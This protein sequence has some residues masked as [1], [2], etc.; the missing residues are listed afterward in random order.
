[1]KTV[2]IF[3]VYAWL[4]ETFYRFGEITLAEINERWVKT[5]MSGGVPML[6]QTFNRYRRDMEEMYG[7]SVVC[8]KSRN[9][10]YIADEG[11]LLQNE[12]KNWMLDTLS[13]SNMVMESASLK[14]RILIEHIPAGIAY[15]RPIMNA[16]KEN[17]QLL[18]TYHK[19]GQEE[20]YTIPVDPYAI[21]VFKQRWYL[22]G[23]TGKR[24]TPCVYALDRMEGVEELYTHFTLP[25]D[26]SAK[27]F[28]QD[29]YG[30]FCDS[31]VKAQRIVLRA[32]Y[33]YVSYL[34]TLPLHSSQKELAEASEYADFE[35]Y[36]R[37]TFDFKQELLA[38]GKDVEVL[39]PAS[40]REDILQ[41][42]KEMLERY[43]VRVAEN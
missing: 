28:F 38:Q 6:R 8:N 10:Y 41:M 40:L 9:T 21:K 4:A 39:E 22:L 34:R 42:M 14:D 20:S 5:E 32:Y 37:P 33:P 12:M 31:K 24:D 13:V 2:E 7:M 18:V 11:S 25:A 19:F 29:C 16:M 3:R 17:R 43:G 36:L 1:M 35:L 23:K 26:F 15:L 30:V 27:K